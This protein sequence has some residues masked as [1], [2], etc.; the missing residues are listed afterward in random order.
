MSQDQDSDSRDK[1]VPTPGMR[2]RLRERTEVY[3]Q[4]F[5]ESDR[6]QKY[7]ESR[8]F[9][10]DT[11][12]ALKI[13]YVSDPLPGDYS[14]KDRIAIPYLTASGVVSIKF[15]A[16]EDSPKKYI[17]DPGQIHRIYNP[18]ALV[19]GYDIVITEGELDCISFLEADIPAVALP[20]ASSWKKCWWRIFKNRNVTVFCDGDQAGREMGSKLAEVIYG[21]RIIEAPEGE[22]ANSLL[23]EFGPQVLREMVSQ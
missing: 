15:R 14:F 20:G 5:T 10:L 19:T 6:A 9:S 21:A 3:S 16:T 12:K 17:Y 11:A 18:E 7:W 22:D 2:E 13:G 4:Q 8:G 1:L 23:Q